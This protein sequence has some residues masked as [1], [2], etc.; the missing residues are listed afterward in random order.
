MVFALIRLFL[1]QSMHMYRQ[2]G[3]TA[4]SMEDFKDV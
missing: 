2:K 4:V 3:D 1:K